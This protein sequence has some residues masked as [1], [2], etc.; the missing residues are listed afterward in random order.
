MADFFNRDARLIIGDPTSG[1]LEIKDLR[2]SFNVELSLVG[3]PNI[4]TIQVYNLNR[5]NRKIFKSKHLILVRL[6]CSLR[7]SGVNRFR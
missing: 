7:L 3:F 5:S 1:G 2:I 6:R 4:A